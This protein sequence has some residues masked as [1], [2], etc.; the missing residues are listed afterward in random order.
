M[1]VML[2]QAGIL[3]VAVTLPRLDTG[4]RRYDRMFV[5]NPAGILPPIYF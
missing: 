3:F 1:N 4:F 2:A 5:P